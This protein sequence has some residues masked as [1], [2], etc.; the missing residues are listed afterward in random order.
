MTLNYKKWVGTIQEGESWGHIR[1]LP[2]GGSVTVVLDINCSDI[3]ISPV[4]CSLQ[5]LS[6]MRK[7]AVVTVQSDYRHRLVLR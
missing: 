5:D 7:W 3:G 6:R 4:Y 1:I 2:S